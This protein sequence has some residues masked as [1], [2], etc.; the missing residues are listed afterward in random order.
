MRLFDSHAR[1]SSGIPDPNGTAVVIKFNNILELEQYVYCL[2]FEL[3]TNIYEIVPV[4]INNLI[5][6]KEKTKGPFTLHDFF[7]TV[8]MKIVR[9]P[10]NS[11][12]DLFTFPNF[13]P[14]QIARKIIWFCKN[15]S[16]TC[17]VASF[18]VSGRT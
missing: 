10:Q 4:Q 7:G 3:H 5:P 17:T 6:F 11:T 9:V 18:L 16:E 14:C 15:S 2:S 8:W 13:P 12:N 1:D